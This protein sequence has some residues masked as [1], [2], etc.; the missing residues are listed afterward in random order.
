[1]AP[2]Q[3]TEQRQKSVSAEP[4]APRLRD[5]PE[6]A[7]LVCFAVADE[8]GA[9]GIDKDAV[10]PRHRTEEG[11]AVG[12][13]ALLTGA[14]YQLEVAGGLVDFADRV[15]FGVGEPGVAGPVEGDALWAFECGGLCGGAVA[16]E[17]A[18]AGPGDVVD[19]VGGQIKFEDLVAFACGEPE[20][21]F[22]VKIEGTRPFQ[23]RSGNGRAVR[24]GAC[25][26]CA[27][28]G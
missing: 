4:A 13:I 2:R 23:G 21:A 19:A 5:A 25:G 1:M 16:G 10:K 17:A 6:D 24:G 28:K 12:A 15:A 26:A 14:G 8:D 20:V 9:V 27:C 3:S 22:G 11:V 7:H 18:G